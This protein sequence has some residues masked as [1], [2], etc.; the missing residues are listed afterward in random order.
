MAANKKDGDLKR[1]EVKYVRDRAKA[2][3]PK[4]DECR[5]CGTTDNLEFHHFAS[6]TLLWERWKKQNGIT[7]NSVEDIEFYRDTFIAE[8]EKELYQDAVTLCLTHHQGLHSIY[9]AKPM[10]HTASKQ[11]N[12]VNIQRKK[13]LG[14]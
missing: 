12:W 2:R 11:A 5:I 13:I 10:L 6:L 14:L 7:I 3:Y 4:G 8:H 1:L 9:G